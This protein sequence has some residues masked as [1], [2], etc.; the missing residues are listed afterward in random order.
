MKHVAGK[1]LNYVI[2]DRI[3]VAEGSVS[4]VFFFCFFFLD[5]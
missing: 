1:K 3:L 4:L 2:S 5:I